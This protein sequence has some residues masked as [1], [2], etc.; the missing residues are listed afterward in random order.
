MLSTMLC[1]D[2]VVS[3]YNFVITA[4]AFLFLL[5]NDI[6]SKLFTLTDATPFIVPAVYFILVNVAVRLIY[7]GHDY[8]VSH[9][10]LR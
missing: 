8:Q 3:L 10:L 1:R 9:I 7:K 4:F 5:W 2:G 6:T